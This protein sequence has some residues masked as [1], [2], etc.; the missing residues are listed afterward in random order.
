[1]I[2]DA[3]KHKRVLGLSFS[4]RTHSN[5]GPWELFQLMLTLCNTSSSRPLS[6]HMPRVVMRAL[7]VSPPAAL[8]PP[9]AAAY[10]AAAVLPFGRMTSMATTTMPSNAMVSRSCMAISD[11]VPVP[12]Q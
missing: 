11:A 6:V 5:L 10:A 4:K 7:L 8:L 3:Q 12:L 2:T 9:V 1:M